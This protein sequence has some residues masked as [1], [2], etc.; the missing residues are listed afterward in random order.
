MRT[1]AF[2]VSYFA[3]RDRETVIWHGAARDRL[4]ALG[5]AAAE[6]GLVSYRWALDHDPGVFNVRSWQAVETGL[7]EFAVVYRDE[8]GRETEVLRG[9]A[10]DRA[11]AMRLIREVPP[12][13]SFPRGRLVVR[14]C[15]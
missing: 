5:K 1:E 3:M 15:G 10:N 11:D 13:C 4:G 7:S 8:R 14:K 12:E 6:R 2:R 9:V